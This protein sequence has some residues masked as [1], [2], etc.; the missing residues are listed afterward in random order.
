MP[1]TIREY[2]PSDF[3]RLCQIEKICFP[4]GLAYTPEL[5][6][7]YIGRRGAFSL[8]AGPDGKGTEILGF[9]IGQHERATVGHVVALDVEPAARRCGLAAQLLRAAEQRLARLGCRQV[10]LETAVTNEAAQKFFRKMGYVVLRTL[11][12]FYASH[13]LDALL[14]GKRLP[15]LPNAG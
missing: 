13:A 9:L 11:P 2:G 12:G 14:M 7:S 4:P 1:F 15:R 3:N 10:V 5:L 6:H 8:V